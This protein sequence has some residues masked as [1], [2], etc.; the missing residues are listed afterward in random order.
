MTVLKTI[1]PPGSLGFLLLAVAVGLFIRYLWP[2]SRRLGHAW[3]IAV[4]SGYLVLGWP[5]AAQAILGGLPAPAAAAVENLEALDVLVVFDGDNRRGRVRAVEQIAAA[6]SHPTIHVVG[7][8]LILREMPGILRERTTHHHA[9]TTRDQIEW[10]RHLARRSPA[11]RIGIV[12]SRIQAPRTSA[13][14]AR[15]VPG[16]RIIASPLDAELP[17]TGLTRFL[18]SY[19]ALCVSR[20]ALYEHAALSYY[21][22]RGWT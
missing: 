13:L 17:T 19:A 15:E 14:T 21:R 1:G 7:S 22:W 4:V 8:R 12:V 18:P 2:R 16:V 20:D 6:A 5:P 3:L 11:T 9:A 10:V